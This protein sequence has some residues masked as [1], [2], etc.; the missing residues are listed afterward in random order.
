MEV[1]LRVHEPDAYQRDPEVAR[2]LARVARQDAEAARVE[3]QRLVQ[4]E[5][6]G[7]IRHL[8][9][10]GLRAE[11][12]REPGV[13]CGARQVEIVQDTVVHREEATVFGGS[14]ESVATNHPEHPDRVVRRFTP[15]GVIETTKDIACAVVPAPPEITC[16]LFEA[17][18][19]IGKGR[20]A[21]ISFHVST[22]CV[23]ETQSASYLPTATSVNATPVV[24]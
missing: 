16:K 5:L 22:I 20:Q 21:G 23:V 2:F 9:A 7:E 12:L 4:G 6:G 17:P 19:A 24:N 13:L 15:Q 1:P 14:C 11:A 10:P 18:D 8:R 3:G